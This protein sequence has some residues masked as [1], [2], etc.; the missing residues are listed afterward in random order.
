MLERIVPGGGLLPDGRFVPEGTNMGMN[1]WVVNR[2]F[3]TF[4]TDSDEFVPERWLQASGETN[5]QFQARLTKMQHAILTFGAG[6]RICIGK[7]FSEVESDKV[8]A[9]LFSK[10]EVGSISDEV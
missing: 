9:T 8:I 10:Y 7:H 6:P 1:S 5:E 2:D 4:G 3:G